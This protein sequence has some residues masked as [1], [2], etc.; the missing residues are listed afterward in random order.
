MYLVTKKEIDIK[1][2]TIFIQKWLLLMEFVMEEKGLVLKNY[3]LH[4]LFST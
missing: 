2:G 1:K 3:V 4:N